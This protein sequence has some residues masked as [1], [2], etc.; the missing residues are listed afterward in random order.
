MQK[1]LTMCLLVFLSCVPGTKSSFINDVA[2]AG[3]R[4]QF[5]TLIW[6]KL[7]REVLLSKNLTLFLFQSR[8]LEVFFFFFPQ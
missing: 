7:L 6:L 8:W 4:W 3:F 1:C 2:V 5:R